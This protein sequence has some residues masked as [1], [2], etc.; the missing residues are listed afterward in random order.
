[1]EQVS[2]LVGSCGAVGLLVAPGQVGGLFAVK[3]IQPRLNKLSPA[4]VLV[5]RLDRQAVVRLG[6]SLLKIGIIGAVAVAV[7]LNDL[8]WILHLAE[9][10]LVSAFVGS[11]ELVYALGLK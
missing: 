5:R 7:M 4:K 2:A 3:P 1:M 10:E 11:C 8:P 9:L 6:I